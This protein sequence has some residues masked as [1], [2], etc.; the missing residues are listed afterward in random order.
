MNNMFFEPGAPVTT[1]SSYISLAIEDSIHSSIF[2][3]VH[4]ATKV[5][6]FFWNLLGLGTGLQKQFR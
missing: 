6:F 4:I 5:F 2:P 1:I 3:F